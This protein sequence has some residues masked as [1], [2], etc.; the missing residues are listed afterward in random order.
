MNTWKSMSIGRGCGLGCLLGVMLLLILGCG[1]SSPT[2]SDSFIADIPNQGW[3]DSGN[4]NHRFFFFDVS[5]PGG[6]ASFNGNE[7][8]GA[9]SATALTGSYSGRSIS[10]TIQRSAGNVTYQGRFPDKDTMV[11]SSATAG[12]LTLVRS[13]S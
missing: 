13:S 3:V 1:G 10:F 8:I 6:T 12:N 7:F 2:E 5:G 11:L 4:P 9:G